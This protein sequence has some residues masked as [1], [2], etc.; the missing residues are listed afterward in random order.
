MLS[1]SHCEEG[2]T[3]AIVPPLRR[4]G[5]R[6]T[7]RVTTGLL[8]PGAG[9][10]LSTHR[11]RHGESADSLLIIDAA[12]LTTRER[13]LLRVRLILNSYNSVA[14]YLERYPGRTGAWRSLRAASFSSRAEAGMPSPR[15]SP[16]HRTAAS[17]GFCGLSGCGTGHP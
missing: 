6:R 9:W 17:M 7:S 14:T 2:A 15:F 4:R 13:K 16:R 12:T 10:R 5:G 1:A 3:R 8:P 11:V